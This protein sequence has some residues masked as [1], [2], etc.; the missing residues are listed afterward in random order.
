MQC[1]DLT[2]ANFIL[3]GALAFAVKKLIGL[4]QKWK[5]EKML[6][7]WDS[8][9]KD[10][11]ILHNLRRCKPLPNVSPFGLKLE[12]YLRLAKIP[13]EL[14]DANPLGPHGTLPWITYNGTHI[15]DSHLSIQ[16]LNK[17]LGVNLNNGKSEEVLAV[18]RASRIVV[19]DHLLL[20]GIFFRLIENIGAMPQL[21]K[22]PT[23]L[24]L[25]LPI[26]KWRVQNR[27]N[28]NGIGKHT[29]T[30]IYQMTEEDL[31]TVSTLLGNKKF[32]GGD[33][34][35]EDDCGIFGVLAQAVWGLPGSSFER[36][37]HGELIS[38]KN[39]CERMKERCWPD[40]EDCRDKS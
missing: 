39:Y 5:L 35:C 18:A 17:K 30:E 38:V 28:S 21:F 29:P 31:R 25:L 23:A 1:I 3:L 4:F 11:V 20:G 33:E 7:K 15:A 34:P 9:P 2:L 24:K 16:Y 26:M 8:S 32:F 12:T 19:E 14:D 37:A 13:Y 6:E 40:W 36:L 27:L 10:K 22:I